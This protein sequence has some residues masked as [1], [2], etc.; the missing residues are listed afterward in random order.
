MFDI[1][2]Y[3]FENYIHN[4]ADIYVEQNQLT[5][6]LLR[7]GF[8]KPEI[9]KALDWLEQ[10]A[11][12]QYSDESPYLITK[13]QHAI[14]VFTDSECQM[15]NVECRGFLMFVEQIGVINSVT[16]EMVMDRLSALDKPYIGLDDL[17]WVVLMVLFNVPGSEEAYGQMEDLIFDEPSELLH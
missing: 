6:E 4:E 15:L 7:A 17:K 2:M 5:D 3:L 1:L 13:P 10:L 11:D 12:L 16:R 9:F 14:R 8:N